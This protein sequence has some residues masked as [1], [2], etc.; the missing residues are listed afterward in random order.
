MW[1]LRWKK[2]HCDWVSSEDSGFPPAAASSKWAALYQ[3]GVE[4][5]V[6]VGCRDD[7]GG[8]A[9]AI[10][11]PRTVGKLVI[12]GSDTI[13]RVFQTCHNTCRLVSGLLPVSDRPPI[14]RRRYSALQGTT[15][16][17]FD[18]RVFNSFYTR[19]ITPG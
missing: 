12:L 5:A 19:I 14:R 7:D 8:Q 4:L 18:N 16:V 17:N 11:G 13:L 9:P 10:C 1:D 2:W 6:E 3:H 15:K